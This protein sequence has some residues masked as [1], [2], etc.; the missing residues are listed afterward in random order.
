M[1]IT[2]LLVAAGSAIVSAVVTYLFLRVN[3]NKRAAIDAA[4]EQIKAELK[5]PPSE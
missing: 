5:N 1:L 3:P 4:V 2:L